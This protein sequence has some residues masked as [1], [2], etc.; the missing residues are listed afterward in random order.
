M[1]MEEEME[2]TMMM[3]D[4]DE[5]GKEDEIIIVPSRTTLEDYVDDPLEDDNLFEEE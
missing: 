1:I 5:D 2:Q 3:H 4:S